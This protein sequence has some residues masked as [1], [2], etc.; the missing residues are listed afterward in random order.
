M[1]SSGSNSFSSN[2][3]G[4]KMS[5]ANA[6]AQTDQ[7]GGGFSAAN[8]VANSFGNNLFNGGNSQAN[9]FGGGNMGNP[10]F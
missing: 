4:N 5:F 10:F 8:A 7:I 3:L 2:V 6:Q 9:A 1:S